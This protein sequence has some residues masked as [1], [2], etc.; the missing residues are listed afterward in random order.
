MR[1]FV[2]VACSVASLLGGTFDQRQIATAENTGRW[3][4]SQRVNIVFVLADDLGY[5]DL[6]CYGR[7]DLST[8]ALDR[9][10]R[11]GTRF[12]QAYA[13]G[14]EC[15]PTRTAFLTGR[16]QQRFVG[17]ECAIGTGD[18][19]RYDEAMALAVAGKLGLSPEVSVIPRLLKAAGYR[20]ALFG[21]WH[22]GYNP[23]FW[24]EKHGFDMARYCLGGG[25][26]YFYHVDNLGIHN[27]YQ[28]GQPVYIKQ[29]F[30]DMIGELASEF[31]QENSNTPFFLYVSFTAPHSPYQS[32]GDDRGHPL[33]G[34]DPAWDQSAGDPGTYVAMIEQMDQAIQKIL[35]AV[36]RCGLAERTLVIFT[37][38]NGATKTGS[39][40]PFRGGKGTTWEGGIRVP[41]IVRWPGHVPSDAV[42]EQ[43]CLTMDWTASILRVAGIQPDGISRLDGIDVLKL[44]EENRPPIPRT[45]Y[46]RAR[47]GNSTWW[48]VRHRDWKYLRHRMGDKVEEYLFNLVRDPGESQDLLAARPDL[49][50]QLR[51]L[52]EQWEK[53]VRPQP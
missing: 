5:G 12:T 46:W 1:T 28:D 3:A 42:S 47:R 37:S 51:Q 34:N 36:D 8:P 22:L 15:T 19:G 9:L 38:D 11:Q 53:D 16:Y 20:T 4:A 44:V 10:A 7:S 26:D 33:P 41:A 13:N 24:P 21:K 35:E 40:K 50:G 32:P 45:V 25:M 52:L 29:Y 48:A 43:V 2:V 6:P 17:L 30:T 49:A 14:P 39:N 31:I 23:Q 27:L 18:V